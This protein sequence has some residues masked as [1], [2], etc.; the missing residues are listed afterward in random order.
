MVQG[1][2]A[3]G[4][5][6]S[7][8]CPS[9]QGHDHIDGRGDCKLTMSGLGG[10]ALAAV[11]L[12]IYAGIIALNL[13]G[14]RQRD[15]ELLHGQQRRDRE[16]LARWDRLC[17]QRDSTPGAVMIEVIDVYQRAT[18]GTKAIIVVA[19]SEQRQDTW[20]ED[21]WRP[22]PHSIL[23]VK[24]PAMGWGPHHHRQCYYLNRKQHLLGTAQPGTMEAVERRR[25]TET[26]ADEDRW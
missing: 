4:A 10:V 18:E 23:L 25:R 2:P 22:A 11:I 13:H 3:G 24:L 26:A 5:F 14:Q 19:D 12:A 21:R 15:R 1:A 20:F 8:A 6:P 7:D 9:V 16:L 17:T